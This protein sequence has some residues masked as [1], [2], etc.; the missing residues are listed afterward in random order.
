MNGPRRRLAT[1]ALVVLLALAACRG[2]AGR[3]GYQDANMDFG[4]IHTVAV[5]PF[6]NLSRESAGADRVREVFSNMLLSTGAVYVL[7]PGE[8]MRGVN[9]VQIVDPRQP[10]VEEITKLGA[11]LKADAV[12]RGVLRE[13]GEVRSASAAA[14]VVSISV[15]M[16]ETSSGKVVWAA[17]STRGG[18]GVSDRLLGSGGAPMNEVTERAVDDLLE[19]LFR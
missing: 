14:N 6:T 19:K 7:P 12:I 5:L 15:E 16:Y 11:L 3:R 1:S 2:S 9:R 18:I 13:Y 10:S 4:A 8:V 17:A